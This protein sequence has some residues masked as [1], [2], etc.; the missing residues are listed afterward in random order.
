MTAKHITEWTCDVCGD[1][2]RVQGDDLPSAWALLKLPN[3]AAS[4][5]SVIEAASCSRCMDDI[6]AWRTRAAGTRTPSLTVAR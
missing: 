1:L 4:T 5:R 2:A 6:V 3:G